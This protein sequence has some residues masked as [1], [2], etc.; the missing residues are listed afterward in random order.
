MT[1]PVSVRQSLFSRGEVPPELYGR[2]EDPRYWTALRRMTNFFVTM[3]GAAKN[4]A[5]TKLVAAVKDSTQQVRLIP[6]VFSST[7]TY[8][9]EFG[10][11]YVRFHQNG[12]QVVAAGVPYE[13]AT[14]FATATLPYL[15]YAQVGDT[16]TI[17]Y[18]GQVSGVGAIA[19]Q[20][21]KRIAHTNWTMT[22]MSVNPPAAPGWATPPV[23]DALGDLSDAA[24][25]YKDWVFYVTQV[26][27]QNSTGILFETVGTQV[28]AQIYSAVTAYPVASVV[29]YPGVAGPLYTSLVGANLGN[30]PD[31]SP[32]QWARGVVLYPDRPRRFTW[33][34]AVPAG[35][36]LVQINAFRGQNAVAGYVGS[37]DPGTA[38]FRDDAAAP[39]FSHQPPSATDPFSFGGGISYPVCVAFYE[40]RRIFGGQALF[41][42]RLH[43]SRTGQYSN[44]DVDLFVKDDDA[45]QFD[46]A[47]QQLDEIRAL[48]SLRTLL[49]FTPT[50]EY[51]IEGF[52]GSPLTASSVDVKRQMGSRGS[53]WIDPLVIGNT[54]LH[55]QDSQ[56]SVRDLVHDWRTDTYN[57]TY[58]SLLASHLFDGRLIMDATYQQIPHSIAWFARDDGTLLGLTYS[59][60]SQDPALQ[61]VAWHKHTTDGVVENVCAVREGTEDALYL[62]VRR[63]VNGATKRY[64]ER[65]AS[66]LVVDIR[67]CCFLDC[68][69]TVDGRN[70][71]GTTMAFLSD[72][73]Y[74][75]GEEGTITAS[76][77]SFVLG[78]GSTDIGDAIV[79][80]PNGSA[81]FLTIL[82]VTDATHARARLEKALPA[83]FQNVATTSWGWARD[84]FLGIDHLEGKSVYVLGDGDK[85][86][87][88]AVAGGQVVGLSPPVVIAQIGLSYQSLIET[89]DVAGDKVR[90][91]QKIVKA[92][93]LEIISSRGAKA[94]EDETNLF[95]WD[96]ERTVEVG[97]GPVPMFTGQVKIRIQDSAGVDGRAVVVQ[98]DPLPITITA[99]TREVSIGGKSDAYDAP[100]P[101]PP[102]NHDVA[103][104]RLPNLCPPRI[105]PGLPTGAPRET[106]TSMIKERNTKR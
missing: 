53:S 65:M 79:L 63:T 88:F 14:P 33:N 41:L 66:R 103:R 94:G 10:N 71:G 95:E 89:L 56:N 22:S 57:G 78:A 35:F 17:C 5:G 62:V 24:H 15:K 28:P 50:G 38:F 60:E 47:S 32:A 61:V 74:A 75:G 101:L 42:N 70:G 81:Y 59:I 64:V 102:A 18:G 77:A 30:Q 29:S 16:M 80:D 93:M 27:R 34:L 6:F 105:P 19:P 26:L 73:T 3:H 45:I 39:D 21:L 97:F 106:S 44:F 87:P 8:M 90:G 36:T 2:T 54:V 55:V 46:I 4:R 31:I 69:V 37:G 7:Q 25:P 43:G 68:A 100:E 9:L 13:V 82:S 99:L 1:G 49:A 86:G 48:V 76:A 40:Q 83:A 23:I 72:S 104:S 67:N 12:G 51:A 20:E 11:F 52:Q 85:Q 98:D 91:K 92:V 84:S 96:D 58:I